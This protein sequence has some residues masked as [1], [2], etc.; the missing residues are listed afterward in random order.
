LE[1]NRDKLARRQIVPASYGGGAQ[2]ESLLEVRR[3][4]VRY[5]VARARSGN[6]V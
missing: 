4:P 6:V 5:F 2:P 3:H 1:Q